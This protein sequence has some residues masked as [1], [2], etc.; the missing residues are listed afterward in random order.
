MLRKLIGNGSKCLVDENILAQ[1]EGL[2]YAP[3]RLG[4]VNKVSI[5]YIHTVQRRYEMM[6]IVKVLHNKHYNL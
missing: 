5:K 1:K 3:Y 4:A 6:L 2:M